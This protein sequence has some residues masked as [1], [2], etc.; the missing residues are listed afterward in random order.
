MRY[1]YS[2]AKTERPTLFPAAFQ[3]ASRTTKP[4]AGPPLLSSIPPAPP[5]PPQR[6]GG[7][8]YAAKVSVSVT[9]SN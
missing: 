1:K 4:L 8:I 9:L 2:T 6:D 7:F 3:G 5:A